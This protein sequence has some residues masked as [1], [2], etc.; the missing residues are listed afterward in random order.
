MSLEQIGLRFYSGPQGGP[1]EINNRQSFNS[2]ATARTLARPASIVPE[3]DEVR[4]SPCLL[5]TRILDLRTHSPGAQPGGEKILKKEAAVRGGYHAKSNG[6]C[7]NIKQA[8]SLMFLHISLPLDLRLL[9]RW[10]KSGKL[11]LENVRP[12]PSWVCSNQRSQ[13]LIS[14]TDLDLPCGI[15]EPNALR[16][17]NTNRRDW[18]PG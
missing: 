12:P 5:P 14:I 16:Y 4:D 13:Q 17:N 11:S 9:Q 7:L 10:S 18:P 8:P 15:F 3:P 2:F 6:L 1:Q